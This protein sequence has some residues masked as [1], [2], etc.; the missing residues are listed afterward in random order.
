MTGKRGR[1]PISEVERLQQAQTARRVV[2]EELAAM[3]RA[4][5]MPSKGKA[6]ANAARRLVV[7]A[8]TLER[9]LALAPVADDDP[10]M[11]WDEWLTE[12]NDNQLADAQSLDDGEPMKD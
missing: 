5:Q 8:R 3:R 9:L 10:R 6:K 7:S 1:K 4:G 2:D 12:W 11:T